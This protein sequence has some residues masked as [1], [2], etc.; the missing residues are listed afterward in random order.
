MRHH[1]LA[2][3][4]VDAKVVKLVSER[5]AQ[6]VDVEARLDLAFVRQLPA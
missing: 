1:A 6:T 5:V 4:A 2:R 3:L